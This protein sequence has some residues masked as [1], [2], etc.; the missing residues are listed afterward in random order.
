M[1]K[2]NFQKVQ[3][4]NRA[5]DMAPK[6][7]ST[8]TDYKYTDAKNSKEYTNKDAYSSLQNSFIYM[9]PELFID[10][11]HI[12]T[13]RLALID[14]EVKELNIAITNN[15]IIETRDALSDILYVVYGMADVLGIDCK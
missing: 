6:N 15:D 14:E 2:T 1:L 12:I 13:L 11:S 10:S 9:R 5:F 7:P 3:E 4:F 8:Y